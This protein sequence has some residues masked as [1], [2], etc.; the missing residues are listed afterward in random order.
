M[1]RTI[2]DASVAAKWFFEEVHTE[3]AVRL[4]DSRHRLHAPDLL[5]AEVDNVV[6][7]RVRRSEIT[8]A[9]GR[10]VRTALRQ[11]PLQTYALTSL[12]NPAFEIAVRTNR[13]L[14]DCVYVALAMLLKGRMATADRRLYDALAAGPL[15][16]YM[17][18]VEDLPR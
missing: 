3:A 7:K 12:L 13:S 14:Y 9:E 16:K 10:K 8:A 1:T 18:W 17:V 11:V 5:L 15:S 6:C 4:L 2:V